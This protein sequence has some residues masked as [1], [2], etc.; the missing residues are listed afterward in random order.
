MCVHVYMYVMLPVKKTTSKPGAV[1]SHLTTNPKKKKKK[2][3]KKQKKKK[4]S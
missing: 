3:K 4:K 2:K 1:Q